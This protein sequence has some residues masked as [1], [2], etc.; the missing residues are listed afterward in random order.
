VDILDINNFSPTVAKKTRILVHFGFAV[1][2]GVVILVFRAIGQDSII[3]VIYTL[4]GYTY[5]PL[6]G[7]YAFGLFTRRTV[8]D[9]VVPWVAV[10]APVCTGILDFNSFEWFG[11]HL[12]YEK[13]MLNGAMTFTGLWIFSSKNK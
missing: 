4:A 6:L 1:M 11:F 9:G 5:G 13:L 7:L 12:G 2:V 8:R 10:L 3:D